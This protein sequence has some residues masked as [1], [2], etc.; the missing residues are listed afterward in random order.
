MSDNTSPNRRECFNCDW[1][2]H[3]HDIL[4]APNPFAPNYTVVGCPNCFS[5]ESLFLCCDEPNCLMLHA[6]G[7]EKPDTLKLDEEGLSGDVP[8]SKH[9]QIL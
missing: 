3:D 2:G 6:L 5:V 7:L 1:R 8:C 9:S 4:R